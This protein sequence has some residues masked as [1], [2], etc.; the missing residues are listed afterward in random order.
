[1]DPILGR[2]RKRSPEDVPV[3]VHVG[4]KY[5]LG[6]S[7]ETRVRIKLGIPLGDDLYGSDSRKDQKEISRRCPR[8]CAQVG[9]KLICLH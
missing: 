9:P 5:T 7:A 3:G 8:G 2:I 1:M 6:K 4:S